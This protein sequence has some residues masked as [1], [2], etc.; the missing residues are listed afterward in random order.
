[1]LAADG[2]PSVF[3]GSACTGSDG[4]CDCRGGHGDSRSSH[5]DSGVDGGGSHGGGDGRSRHGNGRCYCSGSG[6]GDKKKACNCLHMYSLKPG[7]SFHFFSTEV[8]CKFLGSGGG[9]YSIHRYR[10]WTGALS[11][12]FFFGQ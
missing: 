8:P 12:F 7:I 6:H 1:M 2:H 9:G 11:I 5:G 4:N 10:Y 3:V